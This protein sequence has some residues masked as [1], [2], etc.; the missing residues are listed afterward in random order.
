MAFPN[1]IP[2]ERL[3]A[4]DWAFATLSIGLVLYGVRRLAAGDATPS[5]E[6]DEPIAGPLP[7]WAL[8]PASVVLFLLAF[9]IFAGHPAFLLRTADGILRLTGADSSATV[10]GFSGRMMLTGFLGQ[11]LAAAILLALGK[12]EPSLLR[13]SADGSDR[14]SIAAN[15]AGALRLIS[16]FATS[17]ALLVGARLLW[18]AFDLCADQQ[19]LTLPN[20]NQRMVDALLNHH[21]PA[22]PLVATGLFVTL[23]APLLEEIG[24]RGMIYPSFRRVLPRGWAI[25]LVGALFG[26]VHGNLANLL[27]ISVLGAWLCIVRDRHGLLTCIVLHLMVNAWTFLWLLR[28]PEISRL[29]S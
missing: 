3:G 20:D 15:R 21:G 11:L 25:V 12:M 27:P 19:G 18:M 5:R 17:L 10:G 6:V 9:A 22:W 13:T 7:G 29:L 2:W 26:I 8:A 16:L 14:E 24:F 1:S 28:A 4:W 23:G